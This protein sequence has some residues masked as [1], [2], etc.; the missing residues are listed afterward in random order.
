VYVR[1]SGLVHALLGLRTLDDLLAHPVAGGSWEGWVIEN[2]ISAA[3]VGSQPWFYRSAGGAELDLV[4]EL[5]SLQRWALEIKRSRS[6]SV[7]RGFHSAADDLQAHRRIVVHS[8]M[9]AFPMGQ[10]VEALPLLDAMD[11]LRRAH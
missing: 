7:S 10:T 1:D 5:P 3:P 2:L 6:P 4:I 9:H 8:G 11:A